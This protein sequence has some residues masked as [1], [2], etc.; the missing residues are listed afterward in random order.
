MVRPTDRLIQTREQRRPQGESTPLAPTVALCSGKGG[1]GKTF[2]TTNLAT[3]AVLEER[4]VLVVDCDFGLAD[5]HLMLGVTPKVTWPSV[6]DGRTSPNDVITETPHG[7]DLVAGGYGIDEA[8]RIQHGGLDW[9]RSAIAVWRTQYDLV[10]LDVGAGLTSTTA[11]TL[12]IADAIVVVTLPELAAMTD[13]Y[14]VVKCTSRRMP[15]TPT[16][17]A[18]NRVPDLESGYTTWR[19]IDSVARRFLG[20]GIEHLGSVAEAREAGRRRIDEL[21]FTLRQP[22]TATALDIAVLFDELQSF[23][24]SIRRP[25][26]AAA[27]TATES[28]PRSGAMPSG[29]N[30]EKTDPAPGGS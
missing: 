15:Q 26:T 21:P 2:L 7:V 11:A 29:A 14:A 24:E 22:E 9:L 25:I 4:R 6:A 8:N 18:V 30:A 5:A 20:H 28:Q 12:A 1:T 10:F 23:A 16:R 3:T 19:K 27:R 17:L 13:A